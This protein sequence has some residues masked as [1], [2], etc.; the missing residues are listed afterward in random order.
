MRA[1]LIPT[2]D[3]PNHLTN[4]VLSAIMDTHQEIA[5]DLTGHFPVISGL[6]NRYILVC[7]IYDCNAILT[8]PMKNRS[9]A[10]HLHAFNLLHLYLLERGFTPIYP[11]TA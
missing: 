11:S 4:L 9:E 6:G 2:P 3:T 1:D 10:E 8:A 7:Y 5:T